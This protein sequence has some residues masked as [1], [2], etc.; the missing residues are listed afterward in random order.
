MLQQQERPLSHQ[1]THLE[2]SG[3]DSPCGIEIQRHHHGKPAGIAAMASAHR[4]KSPEDSEGRSDLL[5]CW[6][7][8]AWGSSHLWSR[9]CPHVSDDH[10]P[11]GNLHP[12]KPMWP[13][14]SSPPP[15]SAPDHTHFAAALAV[16]CTQGAGGGR[17][18]Q[19][20]TRRVGTD[21]VQQ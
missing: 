21:T 8:G 4:A 3:R 12:S 16:R 9:S 10:L 7:G 6:R 19:G 11:H 13:R 2:L 18:S 20:E 15:N 17:L 1:S 5:H 14:G